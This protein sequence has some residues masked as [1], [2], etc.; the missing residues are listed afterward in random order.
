MD[1]HTLKFSTDH[2]WVRVEEDNCATIGI[3]EEPLKLLTDFNKIKFP[4][5]GVE[6]SKDEVFGSIMRDKKSL[7]QLVC[8]LTGEVLSVNDDIED[9]PEVLLED[10]FEEGWLLRLLIQA[11]E[12]L[13]ELLT[14]EEYNEYIE[15]DD[16]DDYDEDEDGEFEDDDEDEE[17]G[18]YDDDDE[19]DEY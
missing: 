6:L 9:A 17:D 16:D 10:N 7:F 15:D 4:D 3:T 8:P 19:D 12:E 1:D 11:P 18:Y 14:H 5:E 13:D 2:V